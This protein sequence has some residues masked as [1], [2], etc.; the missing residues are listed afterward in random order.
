MLTCQTGAIEPSFMLGSAPAVKLF[1]SE[2]VELMIPST[3]KTLPFALFVGWVEMEMG[4]TLKVGVI[5]T[6]L[7]R[8]PEH[9]PLNCAVWDTCRS[10]TNPIALPVTV[11]GCDAMDAA[12]GPFTPP[13]AS[14]TRRVPADCPAQAGKA[15]VTVAAAEV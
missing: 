15:S 14:S 6:E 11:I 8:L 4:A 2:L 7:V 5:G 12:V 1:P 9:P 3:P 10:T 13:S